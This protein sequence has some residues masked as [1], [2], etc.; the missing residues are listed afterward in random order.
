M[1]RVGGGDVIT[2][3]KG[4]PIA[5]WSVREHVWGPRE[6]WGVYNSQLCHRKY[7]DTRGEETCQTISQCHQETLKLLFPGE[8]HAHRPCRR[9]AVNSTSGTCSGE[10]APPSAIMKGPGRRFVFSR[11]GIFSTLAF[12]VAIGG[13]E[14]GG[15]SSESVY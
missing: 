6:A 3:R 14:E 13:G 4:E 1:F 8:K 12:M 11:P 9:S 7:R 5:A 10:G 15:F 2:K